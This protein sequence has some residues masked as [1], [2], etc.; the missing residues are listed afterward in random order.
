MSSGVLAAVPVE[1]HLQVE[2]FQTVL[3]GELPHAS[4]QQVVGQQFGAG[5]GEGAWIA[6]RN[7]PAGALFV[8]AALV[9][10]PM[11]VSPPAARAA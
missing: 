11:L 10:A 2:L 8:V 3:P 9:L 7:E 1:A 5:I 4:A 6:C